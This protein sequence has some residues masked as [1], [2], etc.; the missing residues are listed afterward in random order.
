M[1]LIRK[2]LARI[3][4]S[5]GLVIVEDEHLNVVENELRR[6]RHRLQMLDAF[7]RETVKRYWL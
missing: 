5:Y 7:G 4:K 1:T 3:L 2:I 6:L